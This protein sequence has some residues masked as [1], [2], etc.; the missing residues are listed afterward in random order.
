MKPVDLVAEHGPSTIRVNPNLIELGWKDG[1]ILRYSG[2]GE[3]ILPR[4]N[5]VIR[6]L[7]SSLD[8]VP[9]FLDLQSTR[10]WKDKSKL[11]QSFLFLADLG[12][13]IGY[14]SPSVPK[15]REKI[16]LLE[17]LSKME[18]CPPRQISFTI[19]WG[20]PV[21]AT[22]LWP[23]AVGK[24]S[25]EGTSF[26]IGE[27]S[28]RSLNRGLKEIQKRPGCS[29]GSWELY[30]A[31]VIAVQLFSRGPNGRYY[32]SQDLSLKV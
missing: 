18:A 1:T 26:L 31:A 29:R 8:W 25:S 27:N 23:P 4:S 21:E 24:V 5:F 12:M 6:G 10:E 16:P 14:R 9:R 17:I 7:D 32:V 2:V 30:T 22:L 28:F 13:E 15:K 11:F 3:L 20:F 19:E